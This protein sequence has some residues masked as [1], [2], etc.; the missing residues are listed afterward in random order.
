MKTG[1]Q[2][3]IASASLFAVIVTGCGG[4]TEETGTN[5][6]DVPAEIGTEDASND[7]AA[8]IQLVTA[9]QGAD[10]QANP[11]EDLVIL[12]VRTP[13]EFAERHL[14]GAEMID[15]YR[16]DFAEQIADLDPDVPYLVY[17]R[18]GNRSG[19][20]VA[21]MRELG[22]SNVSDVD[23]GIL[24]WNQAGLPTIAG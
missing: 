13:E 19:Q 20:T 21:L 2:K 22:F 12:D 14:E 16:T 9:D 4:T 10:I 8:I 3:L 6:A 1:T 7:A 17:C 11:P 24:S 23:G 15:F 5:A 18:S